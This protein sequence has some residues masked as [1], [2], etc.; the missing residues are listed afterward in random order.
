VSCSRIMPRLFPAH[1]VA[2]IDLFRAAI[3]LFNAERPKR[4]QTACNAGD[5]AD[6][7]VDLNLSAIGEIRQARP[8]VDDGMRSFPLKRH[9][10]AFE[11]LKKVD[12]DLDSR[13][14]AAG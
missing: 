12:E 9:I 4:V 2:A 6:T 13:L 10:Q 5:F 11:L 7:I 3:L 14:R 8:L 1:D